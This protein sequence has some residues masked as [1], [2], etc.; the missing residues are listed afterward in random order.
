MSIAQG[1]ARKLLHSSIRAEARSMFLQV[2]VF[3]FLSIRRP[4]P[5]GI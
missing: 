3:L 4:L 1:Q 2:G 5:D